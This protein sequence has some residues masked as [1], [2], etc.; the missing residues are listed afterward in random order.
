MDSEAPSLM[1]SGSGN[2]SIPLLI[3]GFLRSVCSVSARWSLDGCGH[4]LRMCSEYV[5][6][7]DRG[8]R[9]AVGKVEH[10]G[11]RDCSKRR[12]KNI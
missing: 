9:T 1:R 4:I 5:S 11:Y 7:K 8:M 10:E 6:Q 12:R 2:T 3:S